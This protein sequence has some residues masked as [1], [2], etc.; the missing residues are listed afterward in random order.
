MFFI[1]LQRLVD[2]VFKGVF[3]IQYL[4]SI[5]SVY[6]M[7]HD[8][9]VFEWKMEHAVA[10]KADEIIVFSAGS[11]LMLSVESMQR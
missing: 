1:L 5:T 3:N 8:M 6:Y 9:Q 2:T 4:I 10:L 11:K 7:Q